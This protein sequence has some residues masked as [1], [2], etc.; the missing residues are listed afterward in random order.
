MSILKY[1]KEK[2]ENIIQQG[3]VQHF[4]WILLLLDFQFEE[5]N[6]S[7][8]TIGKLLFWATKNTGQTL[9]GRPQFIARQ[10][11]LEQHMSQYKHVP[12]WA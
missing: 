10:E 5:E 6:Y 7:T 8:T 1:L 11:H 9:L 2:A 12:V 3:Q 4:Q